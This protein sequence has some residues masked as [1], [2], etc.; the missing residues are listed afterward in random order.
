MTEVRA[1]SWE[2]T[3]SF[4]RAGRSIKAAALWTALI[5][6]ASL[7]A[8]AGAGHLSPLSKTDPAL[9]VMAASRPKSMHSVI[10]RETNPA[11]LDAERRVWA[12]GGQVTHELPIIGSFAA[13][14]P[15]RALKPLASSTAVWRVWGDSR[16]Q[17]TST[18]LS[19]YDSYS[20]DTSWQETIQPSGGTSGGS[21]VTV[22]LLDTGITHVADLGN[23]VLARVDFTADHDGYD[24]HGH[25][26]HMAGII[27]GDGAASNGQWV[28]VAPKANLV[29]VKVAGADGST[30]VSV[31][32]AGLQWIV[33]HRAQY[34]IRVL[35]LSYGTDSKQS[36]LLDPLDYAVERVWR[37]GIFVVA[38][39]GNRGPNAG[40]VSKPGDDPFVLT[41]GG[42]DTKNTPNRNDDE[43]PLFSG[44][45]PTQDGVSKPDLVA[46]AISIV[47]NRAPGSTIDQLHPAARVGQYYFKGTGTSQSAAAVSG[48]AALLFSASPSLSPDLAKAILVRTADRKITYNSGR[49]GSGAGIIDAD[50]ALTLISRGYSWVLPANQGLAPSSGLGSLEASRGSYHV[51]ADLDGDGVP[52]IVK[53]EIDVLGNTWSAALFTG[54]SWT[55]NSWAGNEWSSCVFEGNTW[56]G[57]EWS[58][59]E[60]SGNEWSGNEWS[61]NEWSGDSWN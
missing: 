11:S 36:Y 17:A 38:A 18:D 44:R 19:Q 24:R 1:R 27:A 54:N 59:N 7:L 14:L 41:V 53:G 33:S 58:G 40:S 52:Q 23:R 13:R 32:I 20:A 5:V 35:N 10:V 39:A 3:T 56:S 29:S 25:G 51:S 16:L 31:V 4:P 21:G 34:A 6:S 55:G 42:A 2:V 22:A 47:S 57:N 37:S 49:S 30:D 48:V 46:P 12:L 9:A 50:A 61:G 8:S 45:G 60:W 43:V 15:G 28:G 26:T